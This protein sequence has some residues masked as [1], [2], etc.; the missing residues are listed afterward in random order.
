MIKLLFSDYELKKGEKGRFR[1]LLFQF[2]VRMTNPSRCISLRPWYL[3]VN[4]LQW[5]F[6]RHA[7]VVLSPRA[8]VSVVAPHLMALAV[9]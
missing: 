7:N 2:T 4:V 5:P 9:V 1:F 8:A 6:Q 3:A